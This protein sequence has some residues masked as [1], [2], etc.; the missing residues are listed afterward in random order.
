VGE[1][2]REKSQKKK[3]KI[4]IEREKDTFREKE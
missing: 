1:S 3:K 4:H 2:G